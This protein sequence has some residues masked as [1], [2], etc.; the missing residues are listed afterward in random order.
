MSMYV[1]VACIILVVLVCVVLFISLKS[2]K[3]ELQKAHEELQELQKAHEDLRKV[4]ED[5]LVAYKGIQ[6]DRLKV[7]LGVP[8]EEL[9]SQEGI[10]PFMAQHVRRRLDSMVIDF[11]HNLASFA[12]R[13]SV[14]GRP[15]SGETLKAFIGILCQDAEQILERRLRALQEGD[16]V[17]L[18]TA[19]DDFPPEL[20]V[21]FLTKCLNSS[22]LK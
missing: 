6:Y 16:W 11:L 14:L 7:F 13:E 19:L 12:E 18:C 20:R 10:P 2:K 9:L 3:Q 5:L 8:W 15:F 4:H 1:V 21:Y 17:R 22:R